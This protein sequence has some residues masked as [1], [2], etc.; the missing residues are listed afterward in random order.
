[1]MGIFDDKV[2]SIEAEAQMK[3]FNLA[4][5]SC[6]VTMLEQWRQG[7]NESSITGSVTP[8]EAPVVNRIQYPSTPHEFEL[9]SSLKDLKYDDN[10]LTPAERS[11]LYW[12]C[13]KVIVEMGEAYKAFARCLWFNPEMATSVRYPVPKFPHSSATFNVIVGSRIQA[14]SQSSYEDHWATAHVLHSAAD[15][16]QCQP[17]GTSQA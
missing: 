14:F 9:F 8:T 10:M 1:M 13:T 12:D 16:I 3:P 7:F 6:M 4:Q 15:H 17:I 11:G 5:L 2:E